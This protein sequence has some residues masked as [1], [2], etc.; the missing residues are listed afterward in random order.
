MRSRISARPA[1]TALAVGAALAL[2][3]TWAVAT[4]AGAGGA[5]ALARPGQ[6]DGGA[7]P[8]EASRAGAG[9]LPAAHEVDARTGDRP[10]YSILSGAGSG[11]S[12]RA[13]RA[14]GWRLATMQHYGSVHDASGY[15]AVVTTGKRTAWVFGGTNPGGTSAPVALRW[16]GSRWQ[17]WPLPPHLTGFISDASAPSADDIWAVSYAGGYALHWDGHHWAVVRHWRER[18]ALTGVTA[19][20]ASDVWVFG[21]TAAGVHGL[22]TWHFNG[23]TWT[24]VNGLAGEIYRASAV[25]RHDIWAV[26][27]TRKGGFIEHYD[28]RTWRRVSIGLGQA[29]LDDVLAVARDDVWAVGNMAG[30]H[31]EG[32][33]ALAHFDGRHWIRILTRWHADTGRLAAATSGGVWV[34]ADNTGTRNDALIGHLCFGCQASWVAVR[35]GLGSGISDVAVNPR[36]GMVWISGGFLTKAGGDA[37]VWSHRD[38]RADGDNDDQ[39]RIG[40]PL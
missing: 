3:V 25:S 35:W 29:R 24:R 30:R 13:A 21:T 26:A 39:V 16:N 37:A 27:A 6:A 31:G 15:S 19:L 22:G 17:S 12:A 36:T 23:R 34:T 38:R 8:A 28:G 9:R 40:G 11:R 20:S 7:G 1:R 2:S 5:G 4:W 10:A 32:K 14:A 33:L 18:G